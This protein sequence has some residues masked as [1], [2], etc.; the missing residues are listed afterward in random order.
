MRTLT[1]LLLLL[2][3]GT[4]LLQAQPDK[5]PF[6]AEDWA[7]LRSAQAVAVSPDGQTVLN[8]VSFG[9]KKGKTN[10]EW[11]TTAVDGS[12]PK[13]LNLPEE[14][15]PSGYT[16][17]G[18]ALYGTYTLNKLGQFAEFALTGLNEHATPRL[19]VLLPRGIQGAVPSPDGSRYA[20][21][22]DPREPDALTQT[23]T[24]IEPDQTS[25][26]LVSK[27]GTG[28]KWWCS[29]LKHISGTLVVGGESSA[30]AWSPDSSTLATIST[31]P[32]IGHH[33]VK[34]SIDTCSASG[35]KRLAEIPNF[36][37]RN[38]MGR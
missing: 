13:K 19:S 26:Y 31:D 35:S 9:G 3:T 12:N 2:Q 32:K 24:V 27:D 10:H 14:F 23:R 33:D 1:G 7:E 36:R 6:R 38:R 37:E 30:V 15:E 11:H 28:G 18:A 16:S 34:S 21:L 25:L 17:D 20:L 4:L 8:E 5:H 29:D 22:A